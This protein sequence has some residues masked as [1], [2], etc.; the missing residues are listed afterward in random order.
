VGIVGACTLGLT[1]IPSPTSLAV[2][3]GLIPGSG[4]A[5]AEGKSTTAFPP[6]TV[7]TVKW[8]SVGDAVD[9]THWKNESGAGSYSTS[10]SRQSLP[11]GS[12]SFVSIGAPVTV[13]A[14]ISGCYATTRDG[15]HLPNP[16]AGGV[17]ASASYAIAI[18][19]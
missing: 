11:S 13:T 12:Y 5:F 14:A 7:V 4:H 17:D 8:Y 16:R 10:F 3:F 18:V 6:N 9:F 19:R 1:S 2:G 15:T